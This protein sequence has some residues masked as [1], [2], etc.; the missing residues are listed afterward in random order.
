MAV[1][2]GCA[3]TGADSVPTACQEL[4]PLADQ[5]VLVPWPTY[6]AYFSPDRSFLLLLPQGEPR[7]LIRVDLP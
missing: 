1:L 4:K 5:P 3:R 6:L 7:R 2:L